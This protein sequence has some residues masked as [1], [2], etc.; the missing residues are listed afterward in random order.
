ML[1]KKIIIIGDVFF[2][3]EK[4]KLIFF[5]KIKNQFNNYLVVANLEGSI[6]FNFNK[7]EKK[8]VHMSLPKFEKNEIPD[9]LI[10]SLVNNHVTD[11]GIDNFKSNLKHFG[12]KA[13]VSSRYKVSNYIGSQKF[14]FLADKKEQCLIKEANFLNFTNK[15]VSTISN[16]IKSSIVIIHGGIEFR[17]YPTP[18][19]RALARK[20][21]EYGADKVI[22]HHSH[23]IGHQEYWNGR[24]IHYGLGNAFFSDT[25]D[26]HALDKSISHAIICDKKENIIKLNQLDVETIE[27]SNCSYDI[28]KMS[29][30]EYVKFYKKEYKLDSS[31]RPRQLSIGDIPNDIQFL[32][33]SY[34][35]NFLVRNKL[36]KILKIILDIFFNKKK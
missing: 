22:F 12:N 23:V 10:F 1:I 14:I 8:A 15:E 19:Q 34:I 29:H 2:S 17:Y 7:L 25:Q 6:K 30:S 13:V 27:R 3:N 5:N 36:S 33:W 21:I 11:F 35:A 18:Y 9:N 20:I 4:D 24:L 16:E 26:I 28:N 32:C 31:F